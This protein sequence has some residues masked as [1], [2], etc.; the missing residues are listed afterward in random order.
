VVVDVPVAH[1]EA[2]ACATALVAVLGAGPFPPRSPEQRAAALEHAT[3]HA[4]A[5]CVA[6]GIEV[7]SHA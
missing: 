4:L 2:V 6:L 3:T 1:R 5:I 7:R